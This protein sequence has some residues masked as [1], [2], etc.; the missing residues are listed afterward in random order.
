MSSFALV[1]ATGISLVNFRFD[2]LKELTKQH[3]T[4]WAF[5]PDFS[6]EV[7][8]KL[9]SINVKMCIYPL[10]RTGISPFADIVTIC[11]LRRSFKLHKINAVLLYTPKSVIYGSIA[12][13]FAK[14]DEIYS[15]I[16]GL[17]YAFSLNTIKSRVIRFIQTVLY[18]YALGKNNT[19]IF[20]NP[21]DLEQFCS[22]QLV[23]SSKTVRVHGS[24]VNLEYFS[25]QGLPKNITFL[26]VARLIKE[27]GVLEYLAAARIVKRSNP[28]AK[29]YLVGDVDT[30]ASSLAL[31]DIQSFID[32]GSVDYLGHL[33]D[34]RPAIL[35][36]SVFVLPSYREGTPRSVLEAMA[37]ARAIITT[38][39]PGCRE[40]VLNNINGFLVAAKSV[41]EIVVAMMKFIQNKN[42]AFEMGRSSY[43]IVR[44]LYDVKLVNK[45]MLKI[46]GSS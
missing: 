29:F 27:K 16:T 14:V 46:M 9:S 18:K 31:P 45:D 23:K 20:Q 44:E 30:K 32:D 35:K 36:A 34:V 26:M 4:V 17:G 24:G 39:V 21:D 37:M 38:D 8:G 43:N 1:G 2:L 15:M 40:T 11:S 12:A 42:L 33:A 5:A 28:E 7:Q 25:E 13:Y 10:D 41:D 3:E 6:T 22:T 19:V